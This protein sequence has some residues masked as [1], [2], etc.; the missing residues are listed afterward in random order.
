MRSLVLLTALIA[1]GCNGC[2]EPSSPGTDPGTADPDPGQ[3]GSEDPPAEA[4][5][6]PVVTVRATPSASRTVE[7]SLQSRGDQPSRLAR[8]LTVERRDGDAWAPLDGVAG[9]SL[10]YSCEDRAE[11]C[12]TLVPG[13]ELQPPPWLGTIGD[14]QCE[15]TRCGPAP[16]GTY[17]LVAMACAGGHRIESEPFELGGSVE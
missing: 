14:A 12:I 4:G 6:P 5:P 1:Q 10:R 8:P 15:C 9:L 16:A 3:T 7:V 17:R 13:A 2:G 11:E